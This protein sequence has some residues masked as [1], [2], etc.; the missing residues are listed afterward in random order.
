MPQDLSGG[1][2]HPRTERAAPVPGFRLRPKNWLLVLPILAVNLVLNLLFLDW[3]LPAVWHPD[4]VTYHAAEMVKNGTLA[5]HSFAYPTL[6]VYTVLLASAPYLIFHGAGDVVQSSPSAPQAPE[7]APPGLRAALTPYA[8]AVSAVMGA[9]TVLLVFLTAW[10]I[11]DRTAALLSAWFLAG[12]AG[13]VHFSHFATVDPAVT[14]WSTLAFYLCVRATDKMSRGACF[15]AAV[16]VGLA[17]S[18]KYTALLL[19]PALLLTFLAAERGRGRRSIRSSLLSTDALRIGSG[20][21]LGFLVGTPYAVITPLLFLRDFIQLNFYQPTFAGKAEPYAYGPH[22]LNLLEV[23]GPFLCV[24]YVAGFGSVCYRAVRHRQIRHGLIAVTGLAIYLKM[25]SMRFAPERYILPLLP[26]LAISGGAF[27]G[28]LFRGCRRRST[29]RYGLLAV[30]G[31]GVGFSFVYSGLAVREFRDGDLSLARRWIKESVGEGA[32][33]EVSLNRTLSRSKGIHFRT[34]PCYHYKSSKEMTSNPLYQWL[35]RVYDRMEGREH[36]TQPVE[37][38]GEPPE[39]GL[40]ALLRRHPDYLVLSEETDDRFL[41]EEARTPFPLQHELFTAVMK[42]RTPYVLVADFRKRDSWLRPR[43]E[44]VNA[45][46]TVYR[47]ESVAN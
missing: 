42:G 10:R 14:F 46:I 3:G 47:Y 45:G 23:C 29:V 44:F 26:L 35:D 20:V 16:A 25:G 31:I 34:L 33:V 11:F 21:A 22:L 24:V 6:H 40:S 27:V 28:E 41:D 9:A 36:R 38:K 19:L 13:L 5:P 2:T 12:T 37:M 30:V 7:S 15:V 43:L 1:R 17:I 8:R 39:V 18:A 4:E 32:T